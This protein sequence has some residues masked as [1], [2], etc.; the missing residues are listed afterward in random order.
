MLK[1]GIT[2][3]IGSGKSV[4]CHLFAACGVPVYDADNAAKRLMHD[5]AAVKIKLVEQFGN[6]YDENNNLL[7]SQLAEMV[8]SNPVLL[9]QLNSIVHPAVMEDYIKWQDGQNA[10]YVIRESA[11][12]FE[13]KTNTDLD[14]VIMVEAPET[15]RIQRTMERDKRTAKQVKE[16]IERQMTEED[17]SALAD[18]IILNDEVQPLLPQVWALHDKFLNGNR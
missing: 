5:N 7:R 16:I 3:G 10:A 8:F 14:Y 17:K 2:G 18:L 4:V 12:L 6:I 15:L 11:I 13:S 1:V 9:Q